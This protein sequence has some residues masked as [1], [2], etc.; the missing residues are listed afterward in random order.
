MTSSNAAG[1][2]GL[3]LEGFGGSR[4][5]CPVICCS[6]LSPGYGC[7]AVRHSYRTQVNE[8]P[9]TDS[10]GFVGYPGARCN[11]TNSAVVIGRTADSALVICRTGVGRFYYKG[12]G[13]QNGLSIEIEDPVQTAAGFVAT[14]N[15][16]KYLVSPGTLLITQDANVLSDEPMLQY[17]S[18]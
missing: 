8:L 11:Y 1:M 14:N 9:G 6:A 18:A 13:L 7:L 16:V 3:R 10:Q 12:F 17:W 4:V 15:G 5:R 2:A